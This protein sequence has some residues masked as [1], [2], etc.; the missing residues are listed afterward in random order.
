M[1]AIINTN[2]ESLNA[3]RNLG[4]SQNA[5]Q[6]SL[7]RLSSGLR[8]NS[9]KDDAA[10]MAIADRMTS[11]IRGLNQA[12]RNANDGISLAQTAEGALAEIG[13][14][15][16]R[17]RELSIQSANASNSAAD[18]ASLQSE[19]TQLTEE[20]T[21]VASQTQFNGINLLNGSFST[22][23]FQVGANANQTIAVSAIADAR[24]SALGSHTLVTN[25][26]KM[27][28]V[29]VGDIAA[30]TSGVTAETNL[31]LTTGG[32]TSSAISYAASTIGSLTTTGGA[33]E[34]AA[35]LNS[36]GASLGV[37]ATAT[38]STTLA[39]LS[40]AGTVSF[41][42]NGQAV[43]AV[44]ADQN[45]LSNL[46]SAING[47]QTASG[48]TASFSSSSTK[49]SISLSTT[50]GRN[51]VLSTFANS[52]GTTDTVSFGGSTLTEGAA[53]TISA[54]ATGSVSMSSSQGP[55][56]VAGSNADVFTA[57][58]SSFLSAAA[59][60]ISTAAGAQ[61]AIAALDSALSQINTS[62][63]SLGAYQ[64]RFSSAIASLQTSAEN[65]TAAR[66]RI[67][68]ADFASETAS[69]TRAQILQ[70]AGTAMLAQANQL[71][72]NVLTLLR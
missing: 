70:Q 42:L 44:I 8:I 69:L 54:V 59:L 63:G 56:T 7:Q 60:N 23:S 15:L 52:A 39:S 17:I 62:R 41:T 19:V 3:Q 35:A 2:M 48:V 30:L 47:V 51:I 25:G 20:I 11:Q 37:T 53:A 34:I 33:R 5:L 72:N 46:V 13:N 38:N 1:A 27:S 65:V 4:T 21:R 16:Q 10:G 22:Q 67:Q 36:A 29:A 64:N 12:A 40:A 50:D 66:S 55:L 18:R 71:P 6:V 61:S 14:N 28:A 68:D 32:G 26:T 58:A 9:A 31:T 43:S 57:T 45:D 49:S 24:A